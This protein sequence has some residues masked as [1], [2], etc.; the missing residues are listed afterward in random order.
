MNIFSKIAA[1]LINIKNSLICLTKTPQFTDKI[2]V[3]ELENIL[4]YS[5]R[6]K[7]DLT[8]KDFTFFRCKTGKPFRGCD[9]EYA[10]WNGS[11][12]ALAKSPYGPVFIMEHELYFL[13]NHKFMFYHE[14]ISKSKCFFKAVIDDNIVAEVMY[15][16]PGWCAPMDDI[17]LGHWIAE[18]SKDDNF[19]ER[20]T[21]IY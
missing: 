18:R 5:E 7:Y 10:L 8:E 19:I 1:G 17:D 21:K 2:D 12:Y 14:N 6:C 9:G 13:K 11:L 3:I 20:Y 4:A 16:D 15:P